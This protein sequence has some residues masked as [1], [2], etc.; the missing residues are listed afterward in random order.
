VHGSWRA[1]TASIAADAK[2]WRVR[3][4]KGAATSMTIASITVDQLLAY[5]RSGLRRLTPQE[6]HAEVRRGL[7]LIDI[8]SDSQR[9]TTV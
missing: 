4:P 3:A 5:A 2:L 6:A 8:R 1:H 7:R 9:A